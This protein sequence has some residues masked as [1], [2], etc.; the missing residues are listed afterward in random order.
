MSHFKTL[1]LAITFTALCSSQALGEET[2]KRYDKTAYNYLG[3]GNVDFYIPGTTC[4]QLDEF[5]DN[6]VAAVKT[7]DPVKIAKFIHFPLR[8]NGIG[9]V[10]GRHQYTMIKNKYHFKR[11]YRKIFPDKI[12]HAILNENVAEIGYRGFRFHG[13][14]V[15]FELGSGIKG[16]SLPDRKRRND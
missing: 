10:I 1:F 12:K 13:G 8:V 9:E 3:E 16:I 15:W 4:E 2:C 5:L 11:M 14:I 7:D 6:L